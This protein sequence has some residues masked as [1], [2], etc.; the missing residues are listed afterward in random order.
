[1]VIV[2]VGRK[3]IPGHLVVSN[4]LTRVIKTH[5]RQPV[6]NKEEQAHKFMDE[7]GLMN[8]NIII[9][10]IV[11]VLAS[12]MSANELNASRRLFQLILPITPW[13]YYH[14]HFIYKLET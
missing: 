9:S 3:L 6:S 5:K 4:S 10:I 13:H 2:T 8:D 12:C 1:M 7:K 14:P 11:F